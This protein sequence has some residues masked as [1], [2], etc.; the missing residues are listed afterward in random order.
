MENI[1]EFKKYHLGCGGVFI[2]GFLNIDSNNDLQI[3]RI[4]TNHQG[5]EG[6]YFL[7]YDLR[8]GVPGEDNTLE[9]IYHCHFLEH[10]AYP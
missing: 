7:N 2:P 6:A 8:S 10:L 1:R 9:L 5:I 4:Y 3:G